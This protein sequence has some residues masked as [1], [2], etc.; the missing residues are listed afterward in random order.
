MAS[1]TPVKR[2]L[3]NLSFCC[4]QRVFSQSY[5]TQPRPVGNRKK[6]SRALEDVPDYGR[7]HSPTPQLKM[8]DPRVHRQGFSALKGGS[9]EATLKPSIGPVKMDSGPEGVKGSG[10]L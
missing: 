7:A 9:S 8:V 4:R 1:A 5:A 6:G 10:P 3:P 2:T